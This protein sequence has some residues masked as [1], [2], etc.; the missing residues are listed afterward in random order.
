M[1][2]NKKIAEVLDR[3]DKATIG[4][5]WASTLSGEAEI[6][7]SD[8]SAK[9]PMIANEVMPD[10][11]D[12]ITNSRLDLPALA[13][14]IDAV[15][16]LHVPQFTRSFDADGEPGQYCDHCNTEYPC[17][18]LLALDKGFRRSAVYDLMDFD[19]E[20]GITE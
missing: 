11:A 2:I 9:S 16:Q 13:H 5:W 20:N 19:R 1:N 12:F 7:G 17:P 15:L 10:D 14:A 18:T 8:G 3:S 6:F 4:P